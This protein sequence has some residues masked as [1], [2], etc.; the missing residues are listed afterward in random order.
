MNILHQ[1]IR[2]MGRR[3]VTENQ[4]TKKKKK[5]ILDLE[6]CAMCQDSTEEGR[7]S[8][9]WDHQGHF[10]DQATLGLGFEE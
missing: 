6:A 5:K 4:I 2:E 3:T 7:S 1:K 8:A 9:A 10:M